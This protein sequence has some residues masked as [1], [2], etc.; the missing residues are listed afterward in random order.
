M[1][2]H[3]D[4]TDALDFEDDTLTLPNDGDFDDE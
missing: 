2:D 1:F 3:L 4:L